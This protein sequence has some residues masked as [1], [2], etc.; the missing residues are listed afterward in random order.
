MFRNQY[1]GDNTTWSPQGRI[2]QVEYALEA[3]KQGSAAVGLV[4]T[5]HAVLVC[6]KRAPGE[7]AAYQ[8]KMLTVDGHIG[9][10]YSGLVADARVLGHFM[11]RSAMQ[12]RLIFTRNLPVS[13]LASLVADKAQLNTQ[14]YGRRPYG[15]LVNP[16]VGLLL[17]GYDSAPR[18]FECLPDGNATQYQAVAIGSRAQSC[19]TYLEKHLDSFDVALDQLIVHG[20]KA[21]AMSLQ[22][23]KTLTRDN[24]SV[25]FVGKDQ[26]FTII[27]GDKLAIYLE[28]L[29]QPTAVAEPVTTMDTD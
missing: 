3:V 6:L 10:A 22:Q 23:D 1:D 19:K 7:L 14:R 2:H 16:G 25:G 26:P 17:A 9:C 20:L 21:L 4:S 8:D 11:R 13:R 18:L 12:S 5:T 29:Q 28:M 15:T 27:E 24:C